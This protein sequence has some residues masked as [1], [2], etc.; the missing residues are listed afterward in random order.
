LLFKEREKIEARFLL[1]EGTVQRVG[2]RRFS[3]R[4]ARKFKL[5]GYI[6]NRRDGTVKIFVQGA[7]VS[8]IEEFTKEIQSAPP[9][10][11]VDSLTL[12]KAKPIPRI[13]HFQ[14][15]SGP[16]ALEI[17]EGFGPME[18]QFNDYRQEFTSFSKMTEAKLQ[19]LD[20]KY[21]EIASKLEKVLS[22]L[23]LE[24]KKN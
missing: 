23:S 17:Q 3:E 1:V 13:K 15:R 2:F 6:E 20:Q 14:I 11:E 7:N 18:T 22:V 10:L 8:S 16:L 21:G 5:S 19:E 24:Q 12:T 9:P 4:L